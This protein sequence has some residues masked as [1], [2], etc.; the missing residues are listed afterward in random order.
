[1]AVSNVNKRFLAVCEEAKQALCVVYDLQTLKRRKI[2]T[3]SEIQ[4]S[5]FTDVKFAYSE[6]KLTNFLMTLVSEQ[7]ESSST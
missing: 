2:L 5:K 1:M 3:S 7:R 6:E 4:S